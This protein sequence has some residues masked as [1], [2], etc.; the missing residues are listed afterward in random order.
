M[1]VDSLICRDQRPPHVRLDF[2]P[3]G[4]LSRR[5]RS[6]AIEVLKSEGLKCSPR[7]GNFPGRLIISCSTVRCHSDLPRLSWQCGKRATS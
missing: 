4:R 7:L 3:V 1:T 2:N 5:P 6:M